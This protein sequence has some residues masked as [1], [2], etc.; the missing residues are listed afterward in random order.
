MAE[1]RFEAIAP[2]GAEVRE[3]VEAADH[4][5]AEDALRKQGLCVY[6][7]RSVGSPEDLE[8]RCAECNHVNNWNVM[9]CANCGAPVRGPHVGPNERVELTELPDG[10]VV[11]ENIDGSITVTKTGWRR[12]EWA[13][14]WLVV[15]GWC[16]VFFY[17]GLGGPAGQWAFIVIGLLVGP[18][19]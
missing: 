4:E 6:R 5:S 10:L 1:F 9:V 15:V 11:Q 8:R 13:W 19:P 16:V 3:T 2:D 17:V 12:W 7:L 14:T 18:G